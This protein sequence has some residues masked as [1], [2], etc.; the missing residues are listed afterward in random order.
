[1]LAHY[2]SDR[3]EADKVRRYWAKWGEDKSEA[4]QI[5]IWDK[6]QSD[7]WEVDEWEG[8]GAEGK[9]LK[10]QRHSFARE[11]TQ[12]AGDLDM[13]CFLEGLPWLTKV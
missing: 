8:L 13:G 2:G 9:R 4:S 6:G 7:C 12:S 11:C 10:G 5:L 3:V 1:M